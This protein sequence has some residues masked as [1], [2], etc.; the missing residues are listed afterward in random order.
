MITGFRDS[1]LGH[2]GG[3]RPSRLLLLPERRPSGF[4]FRH[5][6]C[7]GKNVSP[8]FWILSIGKLLIAECKHLIILSDLPG[9][10]FIF[11]GVSCHFFF[12]PWLCFGT[13]TGLSDDVDTVFLCLE[14]GERVMASRRMAIS[15]WMFPK[16]VGFPPKSSH[17]NRVFHYKP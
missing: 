16:I 11:V 4:T 12:D 15:I 1:P 14:V 17:F 13:G 7:W 3:S 5:F 10:W 6:C 9:S 2:L 8:F